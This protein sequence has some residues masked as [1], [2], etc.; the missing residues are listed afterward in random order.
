[1]KRGANSPD[2]A[3]AAY[4]DAL[5]DGV[6]PATNAPVKKNIQKDLEGTVHL[7]QKYLKPAPPSQEMTRRI[8]IRLASE[9]RRSGPGERTNRQAKKKNQQIYIL[10]FATVLV[11][12]GLS[13]VFLIPDIY[14]NLQGS[15]AEISPL[16]ALVGIILLILGLIT[17]IIIHNSRRRKK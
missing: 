4:V 12:A 14:G 15:A 5:L 2:D 1:M 10:S 7:L 17:W 6:E 11:I 8:Q 9:W 13:T 3:L 16:A